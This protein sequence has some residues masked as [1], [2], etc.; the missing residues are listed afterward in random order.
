MEDTSSLS[1]S[2]TP[3]DVIP[4]FDVQMSFLIIAKRAFAVQLSTGIADNFD[5]QKLNHINDVA[6]QIRVNAQFTSPP[7]NRIESLSWP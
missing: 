6:G 5:T 7:I 3:K 2:I 1:A 4:D